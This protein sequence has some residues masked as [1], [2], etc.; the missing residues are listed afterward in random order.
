MK[1]LPLLLAILALSACFMARAQSFDLTSGRIPLASLDGLW[2][3]HIG[4]NPAWAD[5]KFDDSQWPLLRSDK[6]WGSQGYN[7]YSGLAWYRFEVTVPAGM[8]QISLYLP[9]IFTCYEVYADGRLIGTYGKLPPN[10]GPYSGGGRYQTYPLPAATRSGNQIEIALRVWHWPGWVP[11]Y[12]GGPR[13]GGG[14][15]GDSREIRQRD[16]LEWAWWRWRFAGQQTVALL[17]TLAGFGMLAVFLLR[18]KEKEYLWF[19]LTMLISAAGAWH[20]VYSY[21]HVVSSK[22]AAFLEH[23][24]DT[25]AALCSIA[26][27]Q[28]LLKPKRTWLRKLAVA[29]VAA[30]FLIYFVYDLPFDIVGYGPYYIAL[31]L[32]WFP[33]Y[34][35]VISVVVGATRRNS[36]DARL[37]AAPVVLSVSANLLTNLAL[38]TSSLGLQQLV[39][40]NIILTREPFTITLINLTDTLF[41]LAVF[42]ILILRFTRTRSQEERFAS[43]FQSARNVQQ[44]L[45]PS[46]LPQTPGLAIESEYRPAREVGGDFFQVLPD[47]TDD[48]VLI[49]VGDVAGKGLQ[50]GMLAALIVGSI[51]TAATFTTDPAKILALLNERLQGR[52]LVTCLALRISRDGAASLV[53]AGHLPPYLNGGEL[54]MEG[55]LPLGA[56]PG[57]DFPVLQFNL[58][59]GDALMLMT[60]GVAEAQDAEGHLFGFDRVAEMLRK[61]VAA[62]TLATAAQAFGQEDDITVLTIARTAAVPA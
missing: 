55:A 45:I 38:I 62:A 23:I 13:L 26:F 16:T 2:R 61:D 28:A 39:I 42:A 20:Y 5:P 10:R 22:F 41:L 21:D 51:R 54:A 59:E 27:F 34:A 31:S 3:F 35:W 57:I 33:F 19:S 6:D 36:I 14:L 47:A 50:A 4:D 32:F 56:I 11:T 8:G 49:V 46:Q 53:N 15:V 48:S 17:Q 1:K 9:S 44:Y 30:Q 52:G 18:R 29:S 37:L 25:G 43:E 7:G 60:D 24:A 40:A 12:N 58:K